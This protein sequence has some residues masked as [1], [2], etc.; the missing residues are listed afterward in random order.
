MIWGC[1]GGRRR[2]TFVMIVVKTVD[3]Q[4]YKQILENDV[5]PVYLDVKEGIGDAVFM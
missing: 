4:I 3:Q 1:F 5:S 2:D